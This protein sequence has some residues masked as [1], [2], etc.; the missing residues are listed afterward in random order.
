M[1]VA[2]YNQLTDFFFFFF[3]VNFHSNSLTVQE[4]DTDSTKKET[5]HKTKERE[6]K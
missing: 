5:L 2:N 3:N 6:G 1:T 4:G